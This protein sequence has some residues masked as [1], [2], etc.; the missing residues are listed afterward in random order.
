MARV[1]LL[2]LSA[3]LQHFNY[4]TVRTW[5]CTQQVLTVIIM[6]GPPNLTPLD[7]MVSARPE[8]VQ[9]WVSEMGGQ[10]MDENIIHRYLTETPFFDWSSK[11]GLYFSQAQKN[12]EQWNVSNNRKLL[13]DF[14][15][16][17]AG[18]EYMIVGEPQP[19]EDKVL[20]AQGVTTGIWVIRKQD[21]QRAREGSRVHPPGVLLEGRWEITTLGTYYIVGQNVYQAPSIFD[22]VE[23]RLLSTVSSLHKMSETMSSLPR[24]GPASGYGYL[25]HS[26]KPTTSGS[27]SGSPARSCEG[28]LAPTTDPQSL[29][30]ASV[31]LESTIT[32]PANTSNHEEARLLADSLRMSIVYGD[33]YTDENPLIGEPGN[34][35]FASSVTAVKKRRTHEEAAAA[36]ARA[37]SASPSRAVFPKAEKPESVPSAFVTQSKPASKGEKSGKT[38]TGEKAK[39]RKSKPASAG[40]SPTTPS[41]T[42]APTPNPAP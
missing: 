23:S 16:A 10:P 19:V 27:R 11:N 5:V 21:R 12:L 1:L 15:R 26:S 22:V 35:K 13:E 20:A 36:K 37:E 29:R 30:A 38:K 28:S 24:Y 17:N 2:C 3:N 18:L 40:P 9:W 32:A 41:T 39:R 8:I 42:A 6:A 7:E 4:L 34:L 33:E 25:P 14:L 31:Q